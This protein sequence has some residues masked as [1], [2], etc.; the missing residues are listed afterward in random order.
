[1]VVSEIVVLL[2]CVVLLCMCQ[3]TCMGTWCIGTNVMCMCQ[4]VA[5]ADHDAMGPAARMSSFTQLLLFSS[6]WFG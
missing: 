4:W 1:M 2:L 5:L 6:R 3:Y